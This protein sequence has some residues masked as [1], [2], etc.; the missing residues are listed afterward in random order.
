MQYLQNRT[1]LIIAIYFFSN[2]IIYIDRYQIFTFSHKKKSVRN[3][4]FLRQ[5]FG[6]LIEYT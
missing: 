2:D 5:S 6:D 4:F 1:K 3:V